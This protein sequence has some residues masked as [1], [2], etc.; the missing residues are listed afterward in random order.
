METAYAKGASRWRVQTR[1]ALRLASIPAFTIA[2]VLVGTLLAG[3]VLTETIF[4]WPGLGQLTYIAISARDL[5]VVQGA[6]LLI[7]VTAAV[8]TWGT[9]GRRDAVPAA[10]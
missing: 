6:L 3:A 8:L 10:S 5:L 4:S 7:A 2:G 1:H 9:L